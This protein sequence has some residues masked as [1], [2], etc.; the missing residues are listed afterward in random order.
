[1]I[2]SNDLACGAK[3]CSPPEW[4]AINLEAPSFMASSFFL[5]ECEMAVTL[6]PKALANNKAKCP[7]PPIPMTPTSTP[8][9]APLETRGL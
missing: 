9:P 5:S 8:G 6:A 4:V 7:R 3:S 1:M 2:K